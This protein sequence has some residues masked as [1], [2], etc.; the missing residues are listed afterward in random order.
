MA[1]VN[2]EGVPDVQPQV[3]ASNDYERIEANPNEFGAPIAQG[4]EKLGQGLLQASQFYGK[5][6]ADNATNNFLEEKEKLLY[7]DP[8]KVSMGPDGTPQQDGGFY[9]LRGAAAMSARPEVEQRLNEI[10]QEQRQNLSTPESKYQFDVDTRRYR[11]QELE[12]IGSYTDQ[13]QKIW[14]TNTNNTSAMLAM[15]DLARNPNDADTIAR[16]SQSVRNSYVKNAQLAGEDTQGAILKADQAVSLG[17]IKSLIVSDPQSAQA[18]FNADRGLLGSLPNFDA[19]GRQVQEANYNAMTGPMTDNAVARAKAQAQASVGNVAAPSGTPQPIK[20]AILGQESGNNPNVPNSVQGAVGPGQ[21]EP[22]TFARFAK[23]GEKITNPADNRAVSGRYINH[24]SALPNVQGD[25]ARIA[26]GYFSG[27][28]NIAPAGSPTPYIH[29]FKDKTGKY[30]S[31]YVSDVLGRVHGQSPNGGA[32]YPSTADALNATMEQNLDAAQKEAETAFPNRPDYQERYVDNVRRR[33]EQ[34]ISQQHQQY[35]V[36]THVV[37]SALASDH[38][39]TSETELMAES[40]QV[41]QAWRSMQFNNP[42]AAM[43]IENMFDANAKGRAVTYGTDFSRMLNRVLAPAGDPQRLTSASDL[44][45]YVG[46]GNQAG[47]TNTGA[48]ALEQILA[49][50]GTPQGEAYAA[51]MLQFSRTMHGTLTFSNPAMGVFDK[52]GEERY[53]KFMSQAFPILEKAAEAGTLPKYLDPKGPDYI[54]KLAQTFERG[55]AQLM[56]ARVADHLA[57]YDA[58]L[59]NVRLNGIPNDDMRKG[60]LKGAVTN[61]QISLSDATRIGIARGWIQA[62]LQAK[63]NAVPSS[64]QVPFPERDEQQP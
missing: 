60:F 48:N 9:S 28:K 25:P 43:H 12:R 46:A 45:P 27:E 51:Q 10:I 14:A 36:D 49:K 54:G 47:L 19:L 58:N 30:T 53:G 16:V 7:G 64:P 18:I 37:Q 56:K 57:P 33:L 29:D 35:E 20:S 42:L 3:Q 38:A 11:A 21:V 44:W 13:Q 24:L 63:P 15:N 31:Q 52:D 4:A 59:M 5:V 39:P 23:P 6:A 62:P 55:P 40:P 61:N 50:R 8:N 41:A 32:V 1:R 2:Y 34:T 22:D 26:V 17:R